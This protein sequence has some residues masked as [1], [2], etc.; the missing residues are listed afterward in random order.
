MKTDIMKMG[1]AY[2]K[3]GQFVAAREDIFPEYITSELS[4]LHD[5]V[6]PIGFELIKQTIE[7]EYK[8]DLHDLFL[9]VNNIAL[10]AASIGQVHTAT[11]V[12]YPN[13]PLVIKVQKPEVREQFQNDFVALQIIINALNTCFPKNQTYKDLYNIVV[14]CEQA[15]YKELDYTNEVNNLKQMRRVFRDTDVTV[16]RVISKMST[17]KVIVMEYVKSSKMNDT[18]VDK[19]DASIRLM[20]STVMC[21]MKHGL[22]HGD[23]HPGNIGVLEK[24]RF[25]LYDCGLVVHIKPG[26][27]R[28][29]FSAI[30]S[31]NNER[32]IKALLDN[33]LVYIDEEPIGNIQLNR[34]VRYVMEYLDDV[35]IDI[36]FNKI[37]TDTL[38]NSGMMKFHI[39]PDMF[40]ISRTMSL[41]EGTCK[42]VNPEFSYND[43]IM[44]MVTDPEL[45]AEYVDVEVI[46]KK[47][48]LDIQKLTR[49]PFQSVETTDN[50]HITSLA[51]TKTDKQIT[52]IEIV[53]FVLLAANVLF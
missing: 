31:K 36:F 21:G 3:I 33:K 30:L 12:E 37:Q 49:I 8:T 45:V 15:V 20:K 26:V 6:G 43:I 18:H 7:E 16:P 32:F 14:Q 34:V 53:L 27:L 50:D 39:D 25:V 10:S 5:N 41:L 23:L 13:L 40:L 11:L 22:I 35:D 2:I 1:P 47:A 38:L 51:S 4:E 17:N 46:L 42:S 44:E 9:T 28:E 48:L 19:K 29:V 52:P 24:N